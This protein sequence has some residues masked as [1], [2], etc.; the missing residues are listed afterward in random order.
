M[1]GNVKDQ[2]DL[3]ATRAG[4]LYQNH[5]SYVRF[6]VDV[7]CRKYNRRKRYERASEV[8]S[9]VW[10][11]VLTSIGGYTDRNTPKG[12]LSAIVHSVTNDWFKHEWADCRD[13]RL[14]EELTE[15]KS[16]K[17]GGYG[18]LDVDLGEA[19]RKR[20]ERFDAVMEWEFN[21]GPANS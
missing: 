10:E 8:E 5:E 18:G 3:D 4:E 21:H 11:K 13:A 7:E 2:K 16:L 15:P 14:T 19:E 20:R 6:R 17:I 1:K 12:W 9:A